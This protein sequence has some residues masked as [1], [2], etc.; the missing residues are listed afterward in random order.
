MFGGMRL[1]DPSSVLCLREQESPE[2]TSWHVLKNDPI[3]THIK[4]VHFFHEI[5][6]HSLQKRARGTPFFFLGNKYSSPMTREQLGAQLQ[7]VTQTLTKGNHAP[8][9]TIP[10]QA[11]TWILCNAQGEANLCRLHQ[12]PS[13]LSKTMKEMLAE[14]NLLWPWHLV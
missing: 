8:F 3:H 1:L 10:Y 11:V 14:A 7:S 12:L 9:I 2:R 6:M 4:C 13:T 5:K